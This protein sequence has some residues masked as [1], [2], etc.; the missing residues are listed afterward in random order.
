MTI[1][2]PWRSSTTPVL[3]FFWIGQT[4]K[5]L[6][7]EKNKGRQL[8]AAGLHFSPVGGDGGFAYSAA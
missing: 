1:Y 5:P 7:H 6:I 4:K 8:F 2:L 3:I